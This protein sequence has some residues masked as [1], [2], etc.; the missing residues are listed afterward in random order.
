MRTVDRAP[1]PEALL[2]ALRHIE[3]GLAEIRV[4]SCNARPPAGSS[5]ASEP[6]SSTSAAARAVEII[7]G[8]WLIH[9]HSRSCSSAG[10]IATRAPPHRIWTRGDPG[11]L[12]Q[13][14]STRRQQWCLCP[15]LLNQGCRQS[16]RDHLRNMADPCAQ[17][18]VLLRRKHCY[19][20]S[21]TSNMDSRRSGS[22]P[23]VRVHPSAAVVPLPRTPQPGLPPE[24]SRSSAEHG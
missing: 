1:P 24:R 10:S 14:A 6:N 17:S 4:I 9:A 22:S 12:L 8:T 5:G 16:G 23:A 18:I 3:Y 7:C 21:A 19:A 20:R 15:E 13:C 2:R 11:H